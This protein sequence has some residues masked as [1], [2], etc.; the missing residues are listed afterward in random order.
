MRTVEQPN[1]KNIALHV[2]YL[3]VIALFVG[4]ESCHAD[5]L[6]TTTKLLQILKTK[7][8]GLLSTIQKLT[9][10]KNDSITK[11]YWLS[12]E[13]LPLYMSKKELMPL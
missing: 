11:L 8:T 3:I 13:R 4:G 9:P 1:R 7:L 6:E 2:L 5:S 12:Y 10:A